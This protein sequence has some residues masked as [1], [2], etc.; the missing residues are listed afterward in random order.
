MKKK[1]NK[2]PRLYTI[3]KPNE[4]ISARKLDMNFM[5]LRV[6]NE[7]LNYN[8][9]ANPDQLVY[10]VPYGYVFDFNDDK[11]RMANIRRIADQLQS[12]YFVFDREFMKEHFGDDAATSFNPFPEIT[13]RKDHFEVHLAPKLKKV[14]TMLK[15]G[16]TKGDIE[17]LREF[18]HEISHTLYWLIRQQQTWGLT[19]TVELDDLKIKLGLE[20]KYE[21]YSNFKNKVLEI[22]KEEFKDTWVEF[23]YTP[24]KKGKGGTV[25]SIFFTFKN[26]PKQEKDSPAGHEFSWEETLLSLGVLPDK[27]QEIRSR[28]KAGSSDPERGIEWDSEYVRFSIEALVIQLKE[29][30]K[31]KKKSQIKNQGGWIYSGLMEGHWNDQVKERKDK[32][33]KEVQQTLNFPVPAEQPKSIKGLPVLLGNNDPY[34]LDIAEV[35]EWE[36][37][38]KESKMEG[39]KTFAE[40]MA[41][42]KIEKK[43][44][45]WVRYSI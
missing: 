16:F 21:V 6:Y 26:G 34:V 25:K 27:V 11:N 36:S 28:V 42:S 5:E 2:N 39:K 8:H 33:Q 18:N 9:T 15:L 12:R 44:E 19:W 10:K 13:H 4:L 32:I 37:L 17:T 30:K 7:L 23:D 24:V 29:I 43:G 14:L 45:R 35:E 41:I 31:D 1:V 3:F 22:A 20:G 40:F 38:Y